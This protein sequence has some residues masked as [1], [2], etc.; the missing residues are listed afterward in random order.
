MTG[1]VGIRELEVARHQPFR[2]PALERDVVVVEEPLEFHIDGQPGAVTM[3]TPGHDEDLLRGFLYG[4]GIVARNS[5]IRWFQ[6]PKQRAPELHGQVI[7]VR[8]RSPLAR[9]RIPERA[10]FA[11]SSCGVCGK[12]SIGSLQIRAPVI[13]AP[14]VVES[15]VLVGLP[16]RLRDQQRL[17]A[18]TGGLHAAGCFRAT[19]ELQVIREDVGRHNAVDKVVG[20]ALS[21]DR[22]PLHDS[23]LVVS[24]RLGFEIIQKAV[25]AGFPVVAAVS[26]PSSLAV[27]I[28]D[29]FGV[30]LC[31]FVRDGSYNVYSHPARIVDEPENGAQR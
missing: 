10:L 16:A 23:I 3:R 2:P 18:A 5:D 29:R 13:E 24:G 27:E 31:G 11:S 19:G 28:A 20:W 25:M 9:Q 22:L 26:A 8:L 30:T 7:E 1:E 6:R 4:E 14:L 12:V 21:E 15:S 17:F